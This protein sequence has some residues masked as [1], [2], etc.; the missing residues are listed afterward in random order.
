MTQLDEIRQATAKI[1]ED[2]KLTKKSLLE[3]A[4]VI[5]RIRNAASAVILSDGDREQMVIKLVRDLLRIQIP[6]GVSYEQ[7]ME[8][9]S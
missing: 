4:K 8:D 7:V 1:E 5:Y 3:A 2:L 9:E 6:E